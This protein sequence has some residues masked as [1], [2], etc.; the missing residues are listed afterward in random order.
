ME[1]RWAMQYGTNGMKRQPR[2]ALKQK[3]TE[4]ENKKKN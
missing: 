1:G 3:K 4:R 2:D